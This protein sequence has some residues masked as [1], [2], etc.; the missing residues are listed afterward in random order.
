MKSENEA[1]KNAEQISTATESGNNTKE[2]YTVIKRCLHTKARVSTLKLNKG[3]VNLPCFMPVATYGALK[4]ANANHEQIILCNTFHLRDLP[5][6]EKNNS[7]EVKKGWKGCV[8]KFMNYNKP[9]LTDSGG[10]QMI[11]L[12]N[13]VSEDC[14]TF[15][16]DDRE[17]GKKDTNFFK[18]FIGE[19]SNISECEGPS[20]E[21]KSSE[22]NQK[23][24]KLEEMVDN[25]ENIRCQSNNKEIVEL[26]PERSI[27]IQHQLNSDIIMQLDDVVPPDSLRIE[28]ACHRSVRWLDRCIIE[29][30]RLGN[31]NFLFP[32]IQG[33]CS[34]ELREYSVTNIMQRVNEHNL[35]GVAIGGLCGGEQ[36]D[37][38]FSTILENTN[39]IKRESKEG[40]IVPV[41]T[42]GIGYAVDIL[43]SIALGLD[44][45]DCV[46]PTRTARFGKKLIDK[47][48][49]CDCSTC[50]YSDEYLKMLKGTTNHSML[51]T[52]HNLYFMRKFT[53]RIRA[54]I[55]EDR[56]KEFVEQFFLKNYDN[57]KER[58]KFQWLRKVWGLLE[59][60]Y[61]FGF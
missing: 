10:F 17:G 59:I 21:Q 29:H 3:T 42:M 30:K 7:K 57:D 51:I 22:N 6:K 60:E 1:L 44:M 56:F 43:L 13:A 34:P 55:I 37:A 49:E 2:R 20:D 11:T 36:K 32:I 19:N 4:S 38:F 40:K 27:Q 8:S 39:A 24:R 5:F 16:L 25:P 54:A 46:Y 14:V 31:E 41:Y 9:I 61:S 52:Q 26:T 58:W 47:S 33:G 12:R 45:S 35:L 23:R 28:D 15:E 18:H 48:F 50:K 53:E